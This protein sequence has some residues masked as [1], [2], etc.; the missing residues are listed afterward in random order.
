[1]DHTCGGTYVHREGIYTLYCT[2]CADVLDIYVMAY[3]VNG[4][5]PFA[6]R[7]LVN[8]KAAQAMIHTYKNSD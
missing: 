5:G 1:M 2:Y 3:L 8:K 7:K 4:P 6:Q